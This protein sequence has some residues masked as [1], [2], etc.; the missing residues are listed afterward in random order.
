MIQNTLS[1]LIK[2][3]YVKSIIYPLL[4][5][6]A[7][8]L[9]A[10][11]GSNAYVSETNKN[12]LIEETKIHI[13][14]ISKRS[15]TIIN[16]EF[17]T[18]SDITSLF[19]KT[20]ENFF[21]TYNPL[22]VNTKESGYTLTNTGVITNTKRGEDACTLFFSNAQKQT[23]HRLEKAIATE[24]L[25]T[26][27]NSVLQTN[28]NIAQVYFNSYDS[29]NRLCP[30]M[31]D[32]LSQYA[33]D[34]NI[35]TFNFYYLADA[36]HNPS[37]KV[38]WTDAYLDPAGLGW[39]I[40]AIAPVY[41]GEFL[42]GVVGI[43]VTIEQLI[44]NI[45]SI[46]LPYV[47]MAMLVDEHGAILGMSEALEQHLGIKELKEH[48][49][50]APIAKTISK[51][52]DFNLLTNK[53]NPLAMALSRMVQENS[54]ISVFHSKQADFLITQ[55]TIP[56]THWKFILLLDQDSL[57]AT[58]TKLKAKTNFIGFIV[59][60]VMALFYLIFL[61][62]LISRADKFSRQILSPLYELIEATKKF[63]DKLTS[64]KL[65]RSNIL[66][67]NT[68]LENFSAMSQELQELY[69]SMDKKIKEG[70]IENMETQKMMIYQ[71]R[72]AQMGE[73]ISMIAHQWRQPLGA[74]STV[75]ASMKLK[76]SLK[77]FN[78]QSEQGR[79][80]QEEFLI[81]AIG[82]IENYIQFLTTT[83]DD[84]RNFF[85][86]E[87]QQERSSLAS[88][89]ERAIKIIGK[90]LDV[91]KIVLHVNNTSKQ[92]LITYETQLTQ[93][94]INILKNSQDAILEKKLENGTI[95]L[96]A[97]EDNALFV[98]EIEDNAGGIP[99]SI[100]TK[101]FDPYFSTKAERNGTGLGL[102][103]SKTIVEEHCHGS[104]YVENTP[105]G[106]KFI[107]KIRGEHSAN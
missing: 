105:Q 51:P 30:F 80:E 68:L 24:K 85:R 67:I 17:K 44:K 27:Y 45:L 102:Y 89:I 66:E 59:L 12:V 94:L 96:N 104:L 5:I 49:Y 91:H 3:E 101:V 61:F 92:E 52:Q 64:T 90:S 98:I 13:K 88:I 57:L 42:E 2:K 87:Q 79:A 6:E 18:I 22:H 23:P 26:F 73:M 106:A 19:Q 40:S 48:A 93:V 21:A 75:T 36:A 32:A 11:F 77:K 86:P 71:S 50:N 65:Q 43:D 74:I 37:K 69:D 58:S 10:Y 63:K 99:E 60:G 8:L 97:Y 25:D 70:V 35:P 62:V 56:Q 53:T 38:V 20:H 14:E 82:K 107:I 33:H 46:E 34:I 95:W 54:D 31:P 16:T 15:A 83:I 28:E 72:L 55:N 84:F 1:Q 41:K 76:Q 47:S 29:M 4:I 100:M 9:W 81:N 39:M 7:M 78:L 103:M